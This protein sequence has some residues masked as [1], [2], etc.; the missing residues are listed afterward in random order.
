MHN[1]QVIILDC[2]GQVFRGINYELL[3]L[4]PEAEKTFERHV[5]DSWLQCQELSC[6]LWSLI[7]KE[8]FSLSWTNLR[9]G[10]LTVSEYHIYV[11]EGI[12]CSFSY[13][14]TQNSLWPLKTALE[15]STKSAGQLARISVYTD[16]VFMLTTLMFCEGRGCINGLV[17]V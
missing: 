13:G 15:L 4:D 3:P 17:Q 10:Y 8:L 2:L 12:H 11:S 7:S 14:A 9:E 6:L 16:C 5:N 1:F